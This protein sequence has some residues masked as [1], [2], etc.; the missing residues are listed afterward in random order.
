MPLRP[1][2]RNVNLRILELLLQLEKIDGELQ[3]SGKQYNVM[4]RDLNAM[5]NLQKTF[6]E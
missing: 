3:Y 2:A 1:I 5:Y 6:R 4:K